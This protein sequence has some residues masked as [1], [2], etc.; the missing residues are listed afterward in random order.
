MDPLEYL[1][2]AIAY[3]NLPWWMEGALVSMGTIMLSCL[4]VYAF[5]FVL[6]SPLFVLYFASNFF[7]RY[8]Y[9]RS[10]RE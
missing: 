5:A 1:I 9:V 7:K 10:R 6:A 3:F 4:F 8:V 2:N